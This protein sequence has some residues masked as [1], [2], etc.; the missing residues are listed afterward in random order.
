MGPADSVRGLLQGLLLLYS[1]FTVLFLSASHRA[2]CRGSFWR[3]MV[4][5]GMLNAVRADVLGSKKAAAGIPRGFC[6]VWFATG[7]LV[8][9][10]ETVA[11]SARASLQP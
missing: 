7:G 11:E 10:G 3:D 1:R 5:C 6:A 4:W 9:N 8:L 2:A